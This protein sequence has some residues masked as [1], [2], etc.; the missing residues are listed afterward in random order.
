VIS[1]LDTDGKI[2]AQ[3]VSKVKWVDRTTLKPNDYNPNKVAPPELELLIIS[4]L[5]DGWTQPIVTLEDGTIVDG[6]HRYTVSADKRLQ[7]RFGNMVPTVQ[8]A[9]DPVHRKMSTIRHNRARGTHGILPMA[10]I[11]QSIIEE[12]H[13]KEEIQVRLGMENE[14][15]DRLLDR[16]GMPNKAAVKTDGFGKSWKPVDKA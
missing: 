10:K 3:P 14:E 11:V 1:A 16:S 7:Q 12:G 15:V 8:V 9:I 6:F 13:S 4:I 2:A 5:E